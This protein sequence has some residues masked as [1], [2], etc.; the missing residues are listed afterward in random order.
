MTRI[1]TKKELRFYIM[2]DRIMNGYSPHRS[3]KEQLSF[4]LPPPI[5]K[6]VIDWMYYMRKASYYQ[7]KKNPSFVDKIYRVYSSFVFQYLSLRF[8]FSIGMNV[9]G[10]GL[11]I[12]HYGTIVVNSGVRAGN[13]CVLHTSTCIGGSGKHIGDALYLA[14]GAKI[15]GTLTLGDGVSIAANS[16]VNK[17]FGDN[18]LLVGLP[19]MAKR[20]EY[21][22]WYERDGDAFIK[23]VQECEQLKAFMNL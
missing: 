11:V 16:L 3:L 22:N 4:V 17:S 9:F 18:V 8:G 21:P 2:A 20:M 1:R 7:N 23:R 12:P 14:S 15:M 5:G 10:Y 19:A 6:K 13:Y